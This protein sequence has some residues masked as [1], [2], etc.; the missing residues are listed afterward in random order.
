[1]KANID[2]KFYTLERKIL[3]AIE[4]QGVNQEKFT[5]FIG[6]FREWQAKSDI[7][8]FTI[9]E[10][11]GEKLERYKESEKKKIE[12]GADII[13]S[14][15]VEAEP[16]LILK[17]GDI[18]TKIHEALIINHVTELSTNLESLFF[19]KVIEYSKKKIIEKLA[20]KGFETLMGYERYKK[21]EDWVYSLGEEYYYL[22]DTNFVFEIMKESGKTFRYYTYTPDRRETAEE[23]ISGVA[24]IITSTSKPYDSALSDLKEMAVYMHYIYAWNTYRKVCEVAES[25]SIK[26]AIRNAKPDIYFS[27]KNVSN[28]LGEAY[29]KKSKLSETAHEMKIVKYALEAGLVTLDSILGIEELGGKIE[30]KSAL[31]WAIKNQYM[32]GESIKDSFSRKNDIFGYPDASFTYD[33]H[34]IF[35]KSYTKYKL[36]Q[37]GFL[38]YEKE[39]ILDNR[40]S[41]DLLTFMLQN[42]DYIRHNK[43]SSNTEIKVFDWLLYTKITND[44]DITVLEWAISEA[45]SI[46][47][48]PILDWLEEYKKYELEKLGF[49]LREY[50][51][52]I[53]NNR[54]SNIEYLGIKEEFTPNQ[55]L[56]ANISEDEYQENLV[57]K[58]DSSIKKEYNLLTP[59]KYAV[60]E[61]VN[62]GQQLPKN[63][64]SEAKSDLWSIDSKYK[65]QLDEEYDYIQEEEKKRNFIVEEE[66]FNQDTAIVPR[67]NLSNNIQGS[68]FNARY[69]EEIIK[70]E[71]NS[72]IIINNSKGIAGRIKGYLSGCCNWIVGLCSRFS[73]SSNNQTEEK[74]INS[75]FD[76]NE[77]VGSGVGGLKGYEVEY[78][79]KE[80]QK[81]LKNKHIL[82]IDKIIDKFSKESNSHLVIIDP[83]DI[84]TTS[85]RAELELLIEKAD[86]NHAKIIY[87]GMQNGQVECMDCTLILLQDFIERQGSMVIEQEVNL[88]IAYISNLHDKKHGLLVVECAEEVLQK[89]EVGLEMC[90]ENY[91]TNYGSLKNNDCI[92]E[93]VNYCKNDNLV[94][95][96]EI[97]AGLINPKIEAQQVFKDKLLLSNIVSSCCSDLYIY[98]N[99]IFAIQQLSKIIFVSQNFNSLSAIPSLEAEKT[100]AQFNYFIQTGVAFASL[101]EIYNIDEL[102]DFRVV[103]SL[104]NNPMLHPF[105]INNSVKDN[106][107]PHYENIFWNVSEM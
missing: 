44:S 64:N 102:S 15:I 31:Y 105:T 52:E 25:N 58:N 54:N 106:I 43:L 40:P 66:D 30:N 9:K 13:A 11:S 7:P 77:Y 68:N 87:A 10:E 4:G 74:L 88:S 22:L 6:Q 78:N 82:S 46:N 94:Y 32:V 35:P 26:H 5:E 47:G 89:V 101:R 60:V 20:D 67:T 90:I 95:F 92:S 18:E 100:E 34:F 36:S 59:Q 69:N 29:T 73:S 72:E 33:Y 16:K 104:D 56:D 49:N 86:T 85:H 107:E 55:E 96:P 14:Y 76:N 81:Y 83:M 57:E 65:W 42:L 91:N 3:L 2:K 19:S 1:M 21:I 23:V 41:T 62:H 63:T 71:E 28:W 79:S 97:T 51:N 27:M 84:I 24:D 45:K 17:M 38:E 61:Y 103:L 53:H 50:I 93:I 98:T 48:L 8:L 70:I 37:E 12:K 39:E 99:L 75:S 80:M